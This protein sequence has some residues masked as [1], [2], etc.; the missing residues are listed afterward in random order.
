MVMLMRSQSV[1]E[2]K[3]KVDDLLYRAYYIDDLTLND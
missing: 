2:N 3:D 1:I